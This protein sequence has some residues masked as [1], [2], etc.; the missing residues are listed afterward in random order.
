[1]NCHP[2]RSERFAFLFSLSVHSVTS[3][4]KS[5]FSQ[6]AVLA[7]NA[8]QLAHT[9]QTSDESLF[10]YPFSSRSFCRIYSA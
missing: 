5:P 9:T 8:L 3:A 6:F 4:L 1:M 7:I 10:A 2:E